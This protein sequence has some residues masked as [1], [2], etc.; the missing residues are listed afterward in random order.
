MSALK[1]LQV[2]FASQC[3]GD[4]EHAN[5]IEITSCDNRGWWVKI[6]LQGT[7][8]E[9]VA[10]QAVTENVGADGFPMGPRWF[11]CKLVGTVW[12]G[13]GDE[14]QLERI[15]AAFVSWADRKG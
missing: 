12:H 10:F 13:A 15:I 9:G 3:D 11:D 4:W 14:T 7:A 8:L 2:W 1:Q 6:Q 5:G